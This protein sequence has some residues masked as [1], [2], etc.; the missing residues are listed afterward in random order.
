M[1]QVSAARRRLIEFFAAVLVLHGGAILL[2]RVLHIQGASPRTQ[3]LFSWI[4]LGLT[5]VVVL[6]GLLRFRAARTRDGARRP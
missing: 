5:A 3:A 6:G 1:R 2:Y 4:W